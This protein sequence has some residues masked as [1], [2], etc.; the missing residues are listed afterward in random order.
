MGALKSGIEFQ[1]FVTYE[2]EFVTRLKEV[3][4]AADDGGLAAFTVEAANDDGDVIVTKVRHADKRA[5]ASTMGVRDLIHPES[6]SRMGMLVS[7]RTLHVAWGAEL[8]VVPTLDDIREY[9]EFQAANPHLIRVMA[10]NRFLGGALAGAWRASNV[11]PFNPDALAHL[12]A[13]PD[14]DEVQAVLKPAGINYLTID[15]SGGFLSIPDA[16]EF[17][18]A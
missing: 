1:E 7:G 4:D 5:A 10:T 9:Q 16:V 15:Y 18:D 3:A 13:A 8:T 2:P 14:P 17:F 6:W 11:R 12:F